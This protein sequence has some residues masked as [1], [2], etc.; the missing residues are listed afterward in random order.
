VNI[1]ELL[2]VFKDVTAE[3]LTLIL[4]RSA[5]LV[6]IESQNAAIARKQ[7]ERQAAIDGYDA[8]LRTMQA[9]LNALKA[10]ATINL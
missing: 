10:Q 2:A 5:I 1:D 3:S 9:E 7:A 8:E 4:Q 6:Q